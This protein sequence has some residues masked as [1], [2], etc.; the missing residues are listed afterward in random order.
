V[1]APFEGDGYYVTRVCHTFERRNG[2]LTHFEADRAH[3]KAT[4]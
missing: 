4:A 3:L 1:G 2:H